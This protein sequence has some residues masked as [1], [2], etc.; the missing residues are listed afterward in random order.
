LLSILDAYEKNPFSRIPVGT[1]EAIRRETAIE[2]AR[3]D[4]IRME[5]AQSYSKAKNIT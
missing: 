3:S 1:I 5:D 2:L 4:R